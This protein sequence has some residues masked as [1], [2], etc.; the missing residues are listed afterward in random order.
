MPFG[1]SVEED[2]VAFSL[3]APAA[4]NVELRLR[5]RGDERGLPMTASEQGWF[6]VFSPAARPG[7][8][9]SFVLDQSTRI[10]DPASRKQPNDV[11]GESE[12]VDPAAYRWTDTAWRGRPWEEAVLYEL[13]VGTFTP[14]GTF[15]GVAAKL[16]HLVALGVTGIELMPLAEAPG[17]RNW[18][19]DGVD[20]FAPESRYGTPEELKDLI[21]AAHRRNLMVFLDVVYNHFGPEGNYLWSS[22]PDF[23]TERHHTPW[24][25]GIDFSAR[26]VRDFFLHNALYWLE[27]FHLDG[28]R[29]DAVQ[30]I[31][32]E[33]K[34]HI[35]IEIADAVAQT[36]VDRH[37]HLVLENDDNRAAWLARDTKGRPKAYVAQWND[38]FHHALHV[39]VTG[40]TDGHYMDYAEDPAGHFVRA[41]AEGFA[42]QGERSRYRKGRARGEPSAELPPA[43]F[44][45]FLQNHDQ[46]GNRPHGERI[47]ALASAEAVRAA[48]AIVLLSPQPPMLFM[49]EEWGSRQP[50]HFFCEFAPE[51]ADRVR[52]ARRTEIAVFFQTDPTARAGITDP[53]APEA[54]RD[55]VLQWVDARLEPHAAWL[56]LYQRLL[57][58]RGAALMPHLK[59][60]G[61]ES[62][63]VLGARRR[64]LTVQWRLG[65]GS[66]LRLLANLDDRAADLDVPVAV[67]RLLYATDPV[68]LEKPAGTLPPWLVA[69]SLDAGT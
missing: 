26:P 17:T 65:D 42:Y 69:W 14:E 38:D 36:F 48:V 47:A 49:G 5:A 1:A 4:R 35:L 39:L 52:E 19:Y 3:W 67:G 46:V 20:L 40:E 13:H 2:G 6:S 30:A 29:F 56:G 18:G 63:A 32:D 50:F 64:A 21:C 43:A 44:L 33:S 51:L 54:F 15:A 25:V 7:D 9:Y 34:P 23:F 24:G 28:L 16:D 12:I 61:H 22:A 66:R 11:H 62:H 60:A 53:T 10:P 55:S 68:I 31:R 58:I 41:L 27:E 59:G 37:V 57:R 45:S 8:L